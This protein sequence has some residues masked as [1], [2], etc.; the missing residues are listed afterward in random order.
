MQSCFP[1]IGISFINCNKPLIAFVWV[2]ELSPN[3]LNPVS[4]V[5]KIFSNTFLW[6][7]QIK[8][9]SAESASRTFETSNSFP[10]EIHVENKL[11]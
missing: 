9:S 2:P 6:D 4:S 7:G 1:S 10:I 8:R 3:L 5:W 11:L